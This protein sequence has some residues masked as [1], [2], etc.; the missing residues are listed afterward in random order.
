MIGLKKSDI[1]SERKSWNDFYFSA[2]S[3]F[4]ESV[5]KQDFTHVQNKKSN[6]A[7]T[8]RLHSVKCKITFNLFVSL[9]K[10]KNIH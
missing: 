10:L 7:A 5:S 2:E 6:V 1:C 8:F 3:T 9:I 4:Q